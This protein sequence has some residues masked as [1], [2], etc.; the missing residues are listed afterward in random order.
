MLLCACAYG[1][2]SEISLD[3]GDAASNVAVK[4]SVL[5]VFID[6]R[7]AECMGKSTLLLYVTVCKKVVPQLNILS[8]FICRDKYISLLFFKC[9]QGAVNVGRDQY[10]PR[11]YGLGASKTFFL[12]WCGPFAKNNTNEIVKC[13]RSLSVFSQSGYSF[14]LFSIDSQERILHYNQACNQLG[15]P[16]G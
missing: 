9:E 1:V 5:C 10:C 7:C 4:C 12:I 6:Q 14:H 13:D 2:K 8:V 16:G 11:S 3:T 15:T